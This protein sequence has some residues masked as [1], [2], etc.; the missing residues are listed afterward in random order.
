MSAA[1][2]F[3]DDVRAALEPGGRVAEPIIETIVEPRPAFPTTPP[4]PGK[5]FRLHPEWAQRGPFW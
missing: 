5:P 3:G 4:P 1:A 2:P